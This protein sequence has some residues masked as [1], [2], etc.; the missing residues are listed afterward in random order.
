M[1][2]LAERETERRSAGSSLEVAAIL[3]AALVAA[4][5]FALTVSRSLQAQIQRLLEAAGGWAAATSAIEVPTEGND[6]F[7]ALGTEFNAMARELE[8]RL[9][10]LQPERERLREAIRRVGESFAKGLDR[11]AL[12]E[13][14]VQTAVD[15]VGADSGRAAVR[16]GPAGRFERGRRRGRRRALPRR[17]V[18][19]AEAAALDAG[20]TVETELGE[21]PALSHPLRAQDGGRVLGMITVARDEPRVHRRRARAVRLPRQP[22]RRLDRERRPPRDRAA[23]G[24]HGRADGPVQPPP[25][26]GGHGQRGRARQALRPGDW[27]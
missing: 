10:E 21:R 23:P 22:G 4:F 25:L 1:R 2:L 6:E 15:G 19:A 7:A 9:E 5:A 27:G 24:G 8:T 18:G 14:V 16:T 20:T 17:D 11:D 26:P 13:I 12:L 3:L